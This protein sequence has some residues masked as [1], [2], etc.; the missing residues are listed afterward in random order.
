MTMDTIGRRRLLGTAGV[1][2]A[3]SAGALAQTPFANTPSTPPDDIAA[4]LSQR[5]DRLAEIAVRVG[6]RVA[7][8]QELVISAPIEALPLTRRIT[9]HAYKAGASLVTTLFSDDASTLLRFKY[10]P[11]ESFDKA[12]GWLSGGLATVL[13]NGGAWLLIIGD[14]PALLTGQDPDKVARA[15]RTW[16]Q[17]YLPVLQHIFDFDTNWSF[18]GCAT[19]AWAK[20]VFPNEPDEIAVAKLWNEIFIASRVDT[21][22]PIAAWRTHNETLAA[23]N[24]FL[25]E[26]R[27]AALHFRGPGTD[28]RVGLADDHAWVGPAHTAKNGILFNPNIPCEEVATAPHKDR[29]EGVARSTKPLAYQGTLI[30]GIAVRFAGGRIVEANADK[31]QQVLRKILETDEG[32]RHLGEVALVPESS[33]I[34]KSGLFFYNT[35]LD[36]NAASHVALGNAYKFTLKKGNEMTDAE[37]EHAG[38][39]RSAVHVDFMIGSGELDIDGVLAGGAM[40]PLMR[41]G[42]WA[43]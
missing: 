5:L 16:W 40:E 23:R 38:G 12:P 33:P 42:E 13:A 8:G 21:P 37:F 28:L 2:T 6:L 31:G 11:Q 4:R 27:F 3:A 17:D 30:E 7:A 9:E 32:A 29:V 24:K 25:N 34:A 10:A 41:K 36:E 19:P 22:D 15:N 18:I 20:A 43:A 26:K 39:N 1:L 35:L 14:D